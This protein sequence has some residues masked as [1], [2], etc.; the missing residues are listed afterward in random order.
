MGTGQTGAMGFKN[1]SYYWN[2]GTSKFSEVVFGRWTE[3][4]KETATYPRLST[5]NG[6]NNFRNSTFWMYKTD[7]FRL[8]NVQFTYDFPGKT[9]KGTF[10]DA[11][12]LYCGGNNLLTIAKE[13]EYLE[14]NIGSPQYRSFYLGFKAAF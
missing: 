12:S 2:R 11:L 5:S 9:F 10:I 7:V 3:E 13:R 14:M 8:Q 6:D 1:N 4:T